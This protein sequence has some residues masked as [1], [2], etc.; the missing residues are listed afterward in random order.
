MAR[1]INLLARAISVVAVLASGALSQNERQAQ[2]APSVAFVNG[3]WFDGK[4]FVR[5]TAYT[6][7]GLFTF[8]KPVRLDRTVDLAGTWIVPPFG[9]AHNHNIGTGVEEW[10]RK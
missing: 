8:R 5:R 9:D 7:D 3:E 4:S 6:V 10:D 1:K 2:H